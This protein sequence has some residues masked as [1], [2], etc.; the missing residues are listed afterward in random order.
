[1][2]HDRF[3]KTAVLSAFVRAFHA[4]NDSPIIFNDALA[5]SFVE[6][7]EEAIR[8]MLA[9]GLSLVAPDL[10]QHDLL[11]EEITQHMMRNYLPTA[12][13]LCRARFSEE[14][15]LRSI[16][17]GV[18]Q[19]VILGA[20]LD[21]FAF[22]APRMAAQVQIFE[23]DHP[24]T[25]RFKKERLA[26]MDWVLPPALHWVP[27]DFEC[28]TLIGALKR[29][30]FDPQRPAIFSW[31]GV[32]FYLEYQTVIA[33]LAA[34]AQEAC[35]G[36]EVVFDF[37]DPTSLL[38]TLASPRFRLARDMAS[39]AGEPFITALDPQTL[40]DTLQSI[41]WT[42]SEI[43]NPAQIQERYLSHPKSQYEAMEHC[44]LARATVSPRDDTPM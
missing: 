33:T 13:G 36:T 39:K 14:L 40:A 38:G 43:L 26:A 10:A 34:I 5:A 31:L 44:Y 2:Q 15:A 18:D 9:G 19:Y 35:P 24:A 30:T 4:G 11:P 23:V 21:T 3:S 6:G 22:R 28:T 17:R 7:Q 42:A 16:E 12:H 25:Q 29:A 27:L 20:G 37:I 32:T 41:G 1:M 8:S